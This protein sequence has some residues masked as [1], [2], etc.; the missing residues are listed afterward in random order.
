MRSPRLS[1]LYRYGAIG[2]DPHPGGVRFPIRRTLPRLGR[3]LHDRAIAPG[4]PEEAY[5]NVVAA[6]A[7]PREA[8]THR[9]GPVAG[10]G[11][12]VPEA[13]FAFD[14][15]RLLDS[16]AGLGPGP[17]RPGLHAAGHA[18]HGSHR[19]PLPGSSERGPGDAAAS[20]E[21]ATLNSS[22]RCWSNSSRTWK[23]RS[24]AGCSQHVPSRRTCSSAALTWI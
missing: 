21:R 12:G 1:G 19:Q 16:L 13:A 6:D 10:Q 24:D 5:R 9:R 22:S 3:A 7:R 17:A 2:A 14:F 18:Q 4:V 20:T 15:A 8:A 23:T 11:N